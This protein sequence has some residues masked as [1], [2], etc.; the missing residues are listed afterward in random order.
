MKM[1]AFKVLALKVVTV[2]EGWLEVQ[3]VCCLG[4]VEYFVV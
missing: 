4:V 2:R 1:A 3:I